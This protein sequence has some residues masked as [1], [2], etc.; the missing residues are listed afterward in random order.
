MEII[1]CLGS[2]CEKLTNCIKF[3]I[4]TNML[5]VYIN[6]ALCDTSINAYITCTNQILPPYSL[7]FGQYLVIT[8]VLLGNIFLG[9]TYVTEQWYMSLC[10]WLI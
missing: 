10:S 2:V 6:R 8:F 4:M 1:T 7:V 9:S 5:I 3:F